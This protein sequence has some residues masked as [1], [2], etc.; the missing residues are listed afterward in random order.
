MVVVCKHPRRS[1]QHTF[2]WACAL[3]RRAA[4]GC[5]SPGQP[6]MQALPA[7]VAAAECGWWLGGAPYSSRSLT[8]PECHRTFSTENPPPAPEAA[9]R[10]LIPSKS[11][12]RTSCTIPTM[13]QHGYDS[14]RCLATTY[15]YTWLVSTTNEQLSWAIAVELIQPE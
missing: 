3:P 4:G 9:G 8:L 12:A 13:A 2:P 15:N 10:M 7:D 11:G 5:C 14:R 6:S 1:W